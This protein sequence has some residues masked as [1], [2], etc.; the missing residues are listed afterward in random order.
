VAGRPFPSDLQRLANRIAV[1]G[2]A[3]PI[4][5]PCGANANCSYTAMFDGPYLQCTNST[6]NLTV[7]SSAEAWNMDDRD[8]LNIYTGRWH[9]RDSRINGPGYSELL[10]MPNE[11]LAQR[12]PTFNTTTRFLNAVVSQQ[13][14]RDGRIQMTENGFACTPTRASYTFHNSYQNNI[15]SSTVSAISLA[16]L[17]EGEIS[18]SIVIPRGVNISG[19]VAYNRS[20]IPRDIYSDQIVLPTPANWSSNAT[21]WYRDMNLRTILGVTTNLLAG[22][23]QASE[24]IAS[25]PNGTI[26]GYGNT[27]WFLNTHWKDGL[28]DNAGMSL[29]P[30]TKHYP[31]NISDP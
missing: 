12:P 11:W 15:Q 26:P 29:A 8:Y 22:A 13:Q 20:S 27:S 3:V 14:P 6:R 25:N 1:S 4:R 10:T 2:S 21:E 24:P 19:L 18:S 17:F 23:Y 9:V 5:S 16:P 30:G 28:S 31:K 7:N